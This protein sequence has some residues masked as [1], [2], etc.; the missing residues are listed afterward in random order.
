MLGW[1]IQSLQIQGEKSWVIQGDAAIAWEITTGCSCV[2]V[3]KFDAAKKEIN[4]RG[5]ERTCLKR[6]PFSTPKPNPAEPLLPISYCWS[7][8]I[9]YDIPTLVLFECCCSLRD[10]QI[11]DISIYYCNYCFCSLLWAFA[12][13]GDYNRWLYDWYIMIYAFMVYGVIHAIQYVHVQYVC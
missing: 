5:L 9:T 11:A 13:I 10:Q 6:R 4:F 8:L 1:F 7:I 12:T 3:H 2:S